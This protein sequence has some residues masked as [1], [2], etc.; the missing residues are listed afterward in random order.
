M[1]LLAL[2]INHRTAPVELRERIAFDPNSLLD[3]LGQAMNCSSLN[4]LAIL[5]TC[6]RTELYC[7]TSRRDSGEVLSW[8]G[9]YHQLPLADLTGC[10][11]EH[12]DDQA[13]RHILRVA[14]G[15]DSMVLGEPQILGQLKTAY[16]HAEQ[17]KTLGPDLS[18][19]FQH[20]FSV[21]KQVRTDTEIGSNPVS[22]A[23][24]AVSLAKRI[25]SDLHTNTVLL[26][27]AGEMVEL[28]ARHFS[29][30]GIKHMIVA[31]R[32]LQRARSVA[33]QFNGQ[34]VLL[35]DLAEHLPAADIIVS[36]TASPLPILGKGAIE[37]ALKKRKHRP[38]FLVDIAVPRDIEP[39]VADLADAYLYTIDDLQGVIEENMQARE[40][41]ASQAEQII[42]LRSAEFMDRLKEFE[43]VDTL[44]LYRDRVNQIRQAELAK[45]VA[46]LQKGGDAE[47]VLRRFSNN[48][49]N[50]IMHEPSVNLKKASVEGRN[51]LLTWAKHLFGID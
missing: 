28:V 9:E 23:Y 33:E 6:N 1:G 44:K 50:K 30:N 15:L 2:G 27:G 31:N 48:F 19:M 17:Q 38:I 14:S 29:D 18:R 43:G 37:E 4:E 47:E 22:V 51:D 16:S 3:A 26:I 40:R 7:S 10:A 36:C 49:A 32:T 35:E 20:A 8:L 25:F 42:D 12:W 45:A 34:A 11:Y 39:Q 24:A 41:A 5:S 21:A 46:Q 13:V